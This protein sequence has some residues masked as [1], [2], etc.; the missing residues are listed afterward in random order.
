MLADNQILNLPKV[1]WQTRD[2]LPS[3]SGIYYVVDEKGI[4]WYIGKSKN[5]F[6]RWQGKSHHRH[7]DIHNKKHKNFHIYCEKVDLFELDQREK[8]QIRKFDPHLNDSSVKIQTKRH[9]ETLLRESIVAIADFSFILGV[10]PPRKEIKDLMFRG[11]LNSKKILELP[12]VRIGIDDYS[13]KNR[14]NISSSD[15][16][17]ALAKKAFQTRKSYS[18]KW[19][20]IP[21]EYPFLFRLKV[22]NY[23]VEV[24]FLSF[25]IGSG[26]NLE[27]RDFIQSTIAGEKIN[28]LSLDS[29]TKIKSDSFN[30]QDKISKSRLFQLQRLEPY[31]S[32]KISL[33]FNESIDYELAKNR[34]YKLRDDLKSGKRGVGSRSQADTNSQVIDN[35]LEQRKIDPDKYKNETL[36]LNK[37]RQ[38]L[39]YLKCFNLDPQKPYKSGKNSNGQP[40][41]SYSSVRKIINGREILTSANEFDTIYYLASVDLKAWLL[42]EKYLQDFATLSRELQ[43]N[44]AVT[45]RF[46]VSPRK[47]IVPAKV[48]IK[49]TEIGYSAWIPFGS[50]PEY[51]SLESAKAEIKRRLTNSDLP[52]LKLAFRNEHISKK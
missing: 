23:A 15:E 6:S 9:T 16:H 24:S 48:N 45:D 19:E 43:D 29:L 3:Y 28:A 49:L 4:I 42:V 52:G 31:S 50:S 10:E 30:K 8:Q 33:F 18:N 13:F 41:F 7:L 22:N 5:I 27:S 25:W 39:L 12:I 14:L 47:F 26:N 21:K 51:P 34:L 37:R 36:T 32:D 1:S 2:L 38:P 35:L 40:N 20:F 46:Y 17:E 44:E 11:W